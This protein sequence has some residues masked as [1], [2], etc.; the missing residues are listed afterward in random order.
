MKYMFL[1]LCYE[2]CLLFFKVGKTALTLSFARVSFHE[3]LV[4]S[5]RIS[6][7]VF[8]NT[9]LLMKDIFMQMKQKAD[10]H[11]RHKNSI[12]TGHQNMC[13][14]KTSGSEKRR[15][16]NYPSWNTVTVK[17]TCNT[18]GAS[19]AKVVNSPKIVALHFHRYL[20]Q[21]SAWGAK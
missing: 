3:C 10:K 12:R 18:S 6:G 1:W 14:T 20:K 17:V 5:K 15:G 2:L 9:S 11:V 13:D 21:K 19:S 8:G 16:N 7:S 4:H